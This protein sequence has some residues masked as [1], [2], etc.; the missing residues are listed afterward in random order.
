MEYKM[1]DLVLYHNEPAII[2]DYNYSYSRVQLLDENSYIH[3]VDES[4]VTFL[5]HTDFKDTTK[6]F[7][8]NEYQDYQQ[9]IKNNRE[10]LITSL[11][12]TTLDINN[13]NYLMLDEYQTVGD[14]TYVL[15]K[16]RICQ[17]HWLELTSL[18]CAAL[19]LDNGGLNEL[20][21]KAEE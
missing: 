20:D 10:Q 18:L 8:S 6:T 11:E 15:A 13:T 19:G 2:I 7:L 1:G 4:H 9:K 16:D 14:K 5:K 3:Y 21:T 17:K 12:W